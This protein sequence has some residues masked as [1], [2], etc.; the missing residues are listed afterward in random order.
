MNRAIS[1]VVLLSLLCA[2]LVGCDTQE[3]QREHE[4]LFIKKANYAGLMFLESTD[5]P[6]CYL[7]TVYLEGEHKDC[8]FVH[9]ESM[10][11]GYNDDIIVA[12]PSEDTERVIYNLNYVI[13][14]HSIDL[15]P[16]SLGYPVSLE[17]VVDQWEDVYVLCLSL[18]YTDLRY[19]QML[20]RAPF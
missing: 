7:L 14:K 17:N 18:D 1:I 15:E 13:T 5:G 8:I 4:R 10:S 9:S 20:D 19:I 11:S 16:Y 12:W 2:N 6:G 3:A